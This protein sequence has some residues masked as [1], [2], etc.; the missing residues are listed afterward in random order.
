MIT[1]AILFCHQ[2]Q[3]FEARRYLPP[4]GSG[5]GTPGRAAGNPFADLVDLFAHPAA[6]DSVRM[7]VHPEEAGMVPWLAVELLLLA[8]ERLGV[9]VTY[10]QSVL[11]RAM[12]RALDGRI[13]MA[14]LQVW[15]WEVGDG[16][17]P[18]WRRLPMDADGRLTSH[19]SC[20]DY[21]Q[22]ETRALLLARRAY[23]E[24]RRATDPAALAP[25]VTPSPE[26]LATTGPI[27]TFRIEYT[28]G[29]DTEE[30]TLAD[31]ARKYPGDA[32]VHHLGMLAP[33]EQA[34]G[35]VACAVLWNATRTDS[36]PNHDGEG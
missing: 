6:I 3:W 2:S 30:I 7:F 19:L 11:L 36:G 35:G 34:T 33:G 4:T 15:R 29:R 9:I 31:F 12:R 26:P 14:N 23:E 28:D 16:T 32:T 24:R 22:E 21:V 20:W 1:M 27:P 8:P 18:V 5:S 25:A 10:D 13:A 17:A